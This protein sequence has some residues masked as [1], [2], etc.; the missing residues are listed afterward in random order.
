[1]EPSHQSRLRAVTR[2]PS[3]RPAVPTATLPSGAWVTDWPAALGRDGFAHGLPSRR[4]PAPVA[5]WRGRNLP[6][7]LRGFRRV[8]AARA[9][10]VP[11]IYGALYL[12]V[13]RADGTHE[14]LGLASLRVVTD[15]GV[16]FIVDAF[17]NLTEVELLRYHGMGTGVAA[18]AASDTAL[19]AECTTALNP[20]ST[21]ATGSQ[22]EVAANVF[23]TVGSLTVDAVTAVTEHGIFSQAATGGG[24]LLDRSVFAVKNLASGDSI[25]FTY[26]LTFASG[27]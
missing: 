20:D 17:Q 6:H 10:Q 15:A 16:G 9:L 25:A 26:D 3:N 18:E 24:V 7:L 13:L 4:I 1:M 11:T 19:G 22:T 8:A 21:R 5:R 2:H 23:R 14:A 12:D 27:G